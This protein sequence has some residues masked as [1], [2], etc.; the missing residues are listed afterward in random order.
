MRLVGPVG[1]TQWPTGPLLIIL[2]GFRAFS[3][4]LHRPRLTSL[5]LSFAILRFVLSPWLYLTNYN[6][7]STAEAGDDDDDDGDDDDSDDDFSVPMVGAS[8]EQVRL[9][10]KQKEQVEKRNGSMRA[11]E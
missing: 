1:A 8:Q 6:A 7:G 2:L 11:R 5:C 9:N 10:P 4:Y 3:V